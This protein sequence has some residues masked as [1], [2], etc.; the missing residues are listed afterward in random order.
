MWRLIPIVWAR[1]WRN[2]NKTGIQSKVGLELFSGTEFDLKY[3]D[4]E[5][6]MAY[7]GEKTRNGGL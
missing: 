4:I 1:N 3:T 5:M 6:P 7:L 2:K